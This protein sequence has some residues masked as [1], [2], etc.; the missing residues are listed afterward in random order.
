MPETPR[1][2]TQAR[3]VLGR[4]HVLRELHAGGPR[5][6]A[7]IA[8]SL[9]RLNVRYPQE[10]VE[11]RIR[12]LTKLG[13]VRK[14]DAAT[15]GLRDLAG[16]KA[17]GR[18]KQFAT[19]SDSW[20][21]G[22]GV[23][24]GRS[25]VKAAAI[26]PNGEVL[27]RRE[28]ERVSARLEPTFREAAATV[29]GVL[30]DLSG[31]REAALAGIV[32]ALPAPVDRRSRSVAPDVLPGWGGRG[33][34]ERFSEA[35]GVDHLPV[36]VINDADARA[37]AEGR[38]GLARAAHSAFVL[39]VS[40]GIGGSLLRRGRVMSGFRGLAGELGHISVS[41]DTLSRPPTEL[42]LPMLD[43]DAACSCGDSQGQH[44]EA[45]ASTTAIARRVAEARSA[46]V[47]FERLAEGWQGAPD[48]R[49]A[50]EDAGQLLGQA[51]SSLVAIFDPA[52]VVVTGRF[53]ACG[54]HAVDPVRRA[55]ADLRPLQRDPPE[56]VVD[57]PGHRDDTQREFE[58][59][60]VR[61]AGRLA[62]ELNTSADDPG[63]D[64]S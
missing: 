21:V 52:L 4:R 33:L 15:V 32:V 22:I 1:K 43:P 29:R 54:D 39:K 24:I 53:A 63:K 11:E 51:L 23:E 49:R 9:T 14:G 58:W 13:L 40:G 62:I 36:A 2:R 6:A 17:A 57:G 10:T 61:G 41:L 47:T 18:P 3:V 48:A 19:L 56:V 38:F 5:T 55:F 46:P 31:L 60:G 42:N 25:S 34:D 50:I 35:L 59:V 8:S 12:E 28:A 26:T 27:V 37:I 64:L 16:P 30:E 20:G 7:E 44:L 45:Y